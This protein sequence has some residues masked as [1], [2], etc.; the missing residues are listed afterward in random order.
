VKLRIGIIS[1][2]H[3]DIGNVQ[4]A[5]EIFNAEKVEY[6][7]H[8]GDYIFPGIVVE[9]KK[10]NAKLIGVL[11]N[12]DGEKV[13]LL[14]NFLNIGGELKG[15]IGEIELDGLSFGIYH[16]TDREVK[17]K[18]VDSRKYDVI[19]S[20]HTHKTELPS[21]SSA[22]NNK[23][24]KKQHGDNNNNNDTNRK[25]GPTLVLNPGTAH[26]KV[27][28]ISGAFKEGGVIIFNTQTEEYKFVDL[29]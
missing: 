20:G 13:H 29:P 8:A 19:V 24:E 2:T 10:L 14:K 7:I 3:D 11:G 28:S 18:L 21:V 12:N 17:E 27:E 22:T 25:R 1:D 16:G 23:N 5:I 15:E 26:K 6:V 9:F 4:R